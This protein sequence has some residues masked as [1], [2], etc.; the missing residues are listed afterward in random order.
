MTSLIA[1][2][3]RRRLV[4][5]RARLLLVA[6]HLPV[7]AL[8]PLYVIFGSFGMPPARFAWLAVACAVAILWLQLRH[9][10]ALARGERPRGGIW[11]LLAL[12]V[13]A[14]A[15]SH[16]LGGNWVAAQFSLLASVPMVL[17]GWPAALVGA[18]TW[19][20]FG[21]EAVQAF[22]AHPTITDYFYW[23]SYDAAASTASVAV[24]YASARMAK[25]ATDLR[26]TRDLLADAAVGQERIRV[27]RDLHDLLGRS[28]ATISL[29]GDLAIRLLG[30]DA[31]AAEGEIAS[32]TEV[33][34]E[35]LAGL[36]HVT[37]DQ[38]P[39]T[40]ATELDSARALLVAAGVAVDV[41]GSASGIPAV[42]DEVL[43]WVVREGAT[44]IVRHATATTARFTVECR[45]G[46]A[47]AEIS[48]DGATEPAGTDGSGLSGLTSR[49]RELSGSLAFTWLSDHRFYL[50]AQVPITTSEEPKWTESGCSSPKIST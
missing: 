8:A 15:P 29:K 19:I 35:A 37:S 24:L 22:P 30:R 14:Y 44:N 4:H 27:S 49:V 16:W 17:S 12:A 42:V 43:A 38:R 40:L 7:I 39:P 10:F 26:A 34:T 1:S 41:R 28:L 46:S 2:I 3:G 33:A 20:W 50:V 5:S 23:I 21:A 45:D 6:V 47:R 48:N 31:R 9:S 25:V 13:L 36:R 11:T 32:L 18:G